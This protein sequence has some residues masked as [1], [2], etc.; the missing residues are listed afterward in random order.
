M[1]TKKLISNKGFINLDAIKVSIKETT[2]KGVY[3]R[4]YG[5]KGHAEYDLCPD[6]ADFWVSCNGN[7]TIHTTDSFKIKQKMIFI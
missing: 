1:G 2:K 4:L 5:V 7:V 6:N 3:F